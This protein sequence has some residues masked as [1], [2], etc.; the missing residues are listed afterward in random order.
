MFQ[1]I[2][3]KCPGNIINWQ[4][5][6]D[7]C[8]SQFRSRKV[9]GKLLSCRKE[10]NLNE[11]SYEYFE[12]N[13]GKNISDSIGSIVKCAFQRGITK[14]SEGVRGASDIVE[15]IRREVKETTAKFSF[16][17]VEEFAY[18]D[19]EDLTP[20]YPL[21]GILNMHSLRLKEDGILAKRLSC[22]ACSPQELCQECKEAP[23]SVSV[24]D[25]QEEE[26]APPA[27]HDMEDTGGS[28]LSSESDDEN[29]APGE[30]VWAKYGKTFYPAQIV[31]HYDVPP[32]LQKKLFRSKGKDFVVV[33]WYGEDR[34]SKVRTVNVDILAE[35]K[36]DVA[37]AAKSD[38]MHLLYQ[39]ALS[40][41]RKD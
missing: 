23:P 12:A 16:F 22:T 30:I 15:I 29:L 4:R 11:V 2:R 27:V 1:I 37:R 8:A 33:K 35:N 14:D 13:E 39:L 34:Y 41:L 19:R 21:S 36:V 3:Q 24:P 32:K 26:P 25:E 38:K 6:S 7:G 9:N 28:D 17:I 31:S 40:D 18:F 5:Y 20:E 10:F